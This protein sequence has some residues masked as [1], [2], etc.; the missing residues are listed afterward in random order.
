ICTDTA[1]TLPDHGGHNKMLWT[2]RT[3]SED[4]WLVRSHT[5]CRKTTT[6]F[7]EV[8]WGFPHPF[9]TAFHH[10]YGPHQS[11]KGLFRPLK[12]AARALS[13]A[14]E[15][16]RA[17]VGILGQGHTPTQRVSSGVMARASHGV[18]P[19]REAGPRRPLPPGGLRRP[20]RG[21]APFGHACPP[22]PR[23]S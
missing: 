19:A 9:F 5:R 15:L 6:P 22:R 12:W 14:R 18:C 17:G 2:Q 4:R 13:H 21:V 8:F 20:A 7:R 1:C 11:L 3:S 23:R 10:T 16:I